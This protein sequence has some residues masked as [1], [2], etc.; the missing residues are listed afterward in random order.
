M[1]SSEPGTVLP[2]RSF[3]ESPDAVRDA[4]LRWM[5]AE[6]PRLGDIGAVLAE[7]GERL[8]RGG[9]PVARLSTMIETYH[10]RFRGAMRVWRRGA[11]VREYRSLR[12]DGLEGYTGSPLQMM[13][14][15]GDWVVR[16]LDE[17][18]AAERPMFAELRGEGL[19]HYVLAPLRFSTGVVNGA[20][21]ATDAPGGFTDRHLA[22]LKAILPALTLLLEMKAVRR[23]T[24]ELLRAYV[25]DGPVERI[26]T[27]QVR[28]GD[29]TRMEAAIMA[30]DLRDFTGLS[31]RV[32]EELS[33][34]FLN[35]YFDCV[36]P[37]VKE[38]GGEVLK[39]VGDG[40][41]AIFP[42]E[43]LRGARRACRAAARAAREAHLAIDLLNGTASPWGAP[44]AMGV[45]M[46]HGDVVYGNI[47]SG[48]RLDF[49]VIGRDVNLASRIGGLCGPLGEPTLM[50]AAFAD[51]AG[52]PV[53]AVGAHALKGFQGM[54][55][56]R[57]P[58]L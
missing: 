32:G 30:T 57:A 18:A 12:D 25:G 21:W 35:A 42:D 11:G 23:V 10:P 39:F 14:E 17:E 49:T 51:L 50:S 43:R 4:L 15:T 28:V 58:G 46:H 1:A 2:L 31:E 9:V 29:I 48:D 54:H 22:L 16:R 41:L 34:A 3:D 13:R 47:G 8:E 20:S 26:L 19:T 56:L 5:T 55:E 33:V 53:R 45:S 44:L 36:V 6:A 7:L 38:A 40:V 24:T 27:G 37:A 52:G